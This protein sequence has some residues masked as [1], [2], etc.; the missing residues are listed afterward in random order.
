MSKETVLSQTVLYLNKN[1]MPG[2]LAWCLEKEINNLELYKPG[3]AAARRVAQMGYIFRNYQYS[4][5]T[6]MDRLRVSKSTISVLRR[7]MSI[8]YTHGGN[9]RSVDWRY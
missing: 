4:D 6:L 3:F 5:E 7:K 9:R 1:E 8:D 2:P